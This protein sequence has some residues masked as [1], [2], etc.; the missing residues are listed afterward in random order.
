VDGI[1]TLLYLWRWGANFGKL[2]ERVFEKKIMAGVGRS[3]VM[4]MTAF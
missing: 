3:A 4:M 1:I 2:G